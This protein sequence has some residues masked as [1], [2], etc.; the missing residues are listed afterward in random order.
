MEDTS[1]RANGRLARIP[2]RR[3][4]RAQMRP[5]AFHA[6]CAMDAVLDK[7]FLNFFSAAGDVAEA[8]GISSSLPWSEAKG[9][10]GLAAKDAG[11][12]DPGFRCAQ[13]GLR[14]ESRGSNPLQILHEIL[15]L[16]VGQ[17][18]LEVVVVMID[19]VE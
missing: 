11:E 1:S 14:S 6:A 3:S 12:A 2:M 13:S 18:E 15:L 17:V 5:A 4:P 8:E 19:D 9:E 7:R 16:R 10:A